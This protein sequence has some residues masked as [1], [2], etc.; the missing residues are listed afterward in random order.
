MVQVIPGTADLEQVARPGRLQHL[1]RQLLH[2]AVPGTH[3]AAFDCVRYAPAQKA[4]SLLILCHLT[5]APVFAVCSCIRM[6]E[7]VHAADTESCS[8]R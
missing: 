5:Y 4:R 8:M 6:S 7:L 2:P 1:P 3:D